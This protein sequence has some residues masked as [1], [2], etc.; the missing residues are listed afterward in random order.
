MRKGRLDVA[1]CTQTRT[2]RSGIAWGPEADRNGLHVRTEWCAYSQEGAK[3]VSLTGRPRSRPESRHRGAFA[4]AAPSQALASGVRAVDIHYETQDLGRLVPDNGLGH[5]GLVSRD[6]GR[7]RRATSRWAEYRSHRRERPSPGAGWRGRFTDCLLAF[8]ALSKVACKAHLPL[9][10]M[11][12]ARSQS[13]ARRGPDACPSAIR[14]RERCRECP[15]RLGDRRLIYRPRTGRGS[16][17]G[18]GLSPASVA[19]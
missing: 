8:S 18:L 16:R 17:Y 14:D 5:L 10:A 6:V 9:L 3:A 13:R 1:S 12:R 2:R 19:A 11:R 4:T 7:S 15:P